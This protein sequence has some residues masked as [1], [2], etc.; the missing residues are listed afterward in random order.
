LLYPT[1]LGLTL[2]R[3]HA[4]AVEAERG[5]IQID[6]RAKK[7]SAADQQYQRNSDLRNHQDLREF[8]S[9]P[10]TSMQRL[11]PGPGQSKPGDQIDAHRLNRRGQPEQNARRH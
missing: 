8:D 10:G 7:E 3:S 11:F 4:I 5:R 6:E 2:N 9:K 1:C